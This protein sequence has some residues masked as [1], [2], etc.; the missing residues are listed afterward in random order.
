MTVAMSS[1]ARKGW[2]WVYGML[3]LLSSLLFIFGNPPGWQWALW[4]LGA[5]LWCKQDQVRRGLPGAVWARYA[6][7]GVL[8]SAGIAEAF[9]I[10]FRG[11]LH[12]NLWACLFLWWGPCIGSMAGWG[13]LIRRWAFTPVQ[14]CMLSGVTGLFIEGN[15][16]IARMLLGGEAAFAVMGAP[17]VHMVYAVMFGLSVVL[18]EKVW[19]SPSLPATRTAF[20]LGVIVP[21]LAF[22]A[23]GFVWIPFGRLFVG[24]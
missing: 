5:L 4:P 16:L 3:T 8:W 7:V 12:P 20:V 9:A 19:P 15:F 21:A 14:V 10:G 18:A 6:L 13:F 24:G 11:D 22:Y 1:E 2:W 23:A 17:M